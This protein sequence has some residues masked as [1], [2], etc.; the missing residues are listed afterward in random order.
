MLPSPKAELHVN[1]DIINC[2]NCVPL[3]R[4]TVHR[5]Y[6][7]HLFKINF[8]HNIQLQLQT[9]RDRKPSTGCMQHTTVWL[10]HPTIYK[11]CLPLIMN[12]MFSARRTE[13]YLVQTLLTPRS[14]YPSFQTTVHKLHPTRTL[15]T[16]LSSDKLKVK[17][18]TL[19]RIQTS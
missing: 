11:Q 16:C 1:K 5:R 6:S 7:V 9:Q 17:Y 14:P 2:N 10:L 3:C 8:C 12:N 15:P 4:K 19:P 18:L 13:K